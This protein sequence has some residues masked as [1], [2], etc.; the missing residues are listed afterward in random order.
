[1][2]KCKCNST[3]SI[4]IKSSFKFD[5][6]VKIKPLKV[7]GKVLSFWLKWENCLLIEVRYFMNDEL[8]TDYFFE[9]ELE[10]LKEEIRTGF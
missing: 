3:E 1:M 5:E 10:I 7:E 4:H 2:I 8:K 9:D 6:K